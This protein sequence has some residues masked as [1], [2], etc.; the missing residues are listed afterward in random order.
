MGALPPPGLC[1]FWGVIG[2]THSRFCDADHVAR[3]RSAPARSGPDREPGANSRRELSRQIRAGGGALGRTQ[4]PA[5]AQLLERAEEQPRA[6]ARLRRLR[7]RVRHALEQAAR[8]R[9]RPRAARAALPGRSGCPSRTRGGGSARARDRAGR[10]RR[11][12]RGSRLAAE[13][14][15]STISPARSA[16]PR[17]TRSRVATFTVAGTGR[18][19]AQQLLDRARVE[20]GPCARSCASAAGSRSRWSRPFASRLVVVSC[21]ANSSSTQFETISSLPSVWPSCSARSISPI[22][23]SPGL[24]RFSRRRSREVVRPAPPHRPARA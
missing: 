11:N 14:N 6:P 2:L 23:S 19:D 22:R 17:N 13:R 21:P 12:W 15:G 8:T 24:R 5:H 7:A 3:P 10:D 9:A 18:L 16:A 20:L 1:G 4:L